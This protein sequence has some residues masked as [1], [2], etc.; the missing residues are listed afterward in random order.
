MA[1]S[2]GGEF[3]SLGALFAGQLQRLCDGE[4]RLL[5]ALPLMAEAAHS[6]SLRVTFHQ[7]VREAQDQVARLERA[8][9][10][11]G[12]EAEGRTS[13]ALKGL[14]EEGR[15]VANAGG[16]P[17]VKDAA[18]IAAAQ[19][20]AHYKISA[21]GTARAFAQYLGHQEAARLLQE[22]LIEEA[23]RDRWLTRLAEGSIN[24][25]ATAAPRG[26]PDQPAAG[27]TALP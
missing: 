14:V 22:T 6:Q 9:Q 16:A 23:A 4:R 26:A 1:L 25:L 5:E 11:V 2:S 10:S 7:H 21:Y 20:V 17:A 18:L 19:G 27:T 3:D 15:E 12:R 13:H 8:L 24:A